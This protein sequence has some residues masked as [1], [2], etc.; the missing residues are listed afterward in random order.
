M[1]KLN[2]YISECYA[3][4]GPALK[5]FTNGYKGRW[6][7]LCAPAAVSP[8]TCCCNIFSDQGLLGHSAE[9]HMLFLLQGLQDPEARLTPHHQ[10][11][12]EE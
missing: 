6:G 2:L 4:Q 7:L 12:G 1:S 3:D 11:Q 5:R 10:G 9:A 8:I